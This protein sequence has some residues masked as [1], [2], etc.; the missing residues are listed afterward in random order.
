MS[1]PY[2]VEIVGDAV[3]KITECLH[4]GWEDIFEDMPLKE[5]FGEE[6][7]HWLDWMICPQCELIFRAEM[8]TEEVLNKYYEEDY[9]KQR[10]EE[11]PNAND[12][13]VA[14]R[15]A[16]IQ[17]AGLRAYARRPY[18]G[19]VLDVGCG[20]GAFIH[21]IRREWPDCEI[22]GVEFD[23]NAH[24]IMEHL[25]IPFTNNIA[26]VEPG[27]DLIMMSHVIEHLRDPIEY[28]SET[29]LPLLSSGGVF[30]CEVPFAGRQNAYSA[31]HLYAYKSESLGTLLDRVGLLPVVSQKLDNKVLVVISRKP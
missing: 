17:L 7:D 10:G 19:S 6:P 14:Y 15:R 27:W 4:C 31:S 29:V 23:I 3:E 13:W 20:Q 18:I 11:F 26:E 8:P 25:E 21:Y 24:A 12:M 28:L 2:D 16:A 5:M 30:M 22:L 9:R 1:E